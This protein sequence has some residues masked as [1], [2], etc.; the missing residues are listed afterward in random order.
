MNSVTHPVVISC[1]KTSSIV[2]DT[3][4][5]SPSQKLLI[6]LSH[7]DTFHKLRSDIQFFSKYINNGSTGESG[8]SRAPSRISSKPAETVSIH[9]KKVFGSV[10]ETLKRFFKDEK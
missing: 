3:S 5:V 4:I 10:S 8:I 7:I 9:S 2:V 6:L 1:R